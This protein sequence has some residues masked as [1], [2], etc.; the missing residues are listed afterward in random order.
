MSALIC[1]SFAYDNI[2]RF[3]GRFRDHILPD[4]IANLNVAFNV[5][6][7]RR[8]FGGC[9]GN[10]AYNLR[11]LG[12]DPL[13]LGT[14]GN[15]F[16]PYA[17][18]MERHQIPATHARVIESAYT[19]QAYITTD[20][21]DNQI[22][23]FHPGAMYHSHE[24]KVSDASGVTV[25]TVSPDGKQ[26]MVEH[27]AQFAEAGIRFFF[28]P[29]QAIPLFDGK[30]L[31]S[32]VEQ[33]TWMTVNEYEAHM[34][35][36]KTGCSLSDLM[37]HLE[38]IVVTRGK[39]GSTIHTR[40]KA[41]EIPIAKPERVVDPTGCGDAYRGGLLYGID[42]GMDWEAAGHI[43]ALA[44]AYNVEQS[45]TQNHRYDRGQF[46]QRFRDTFGFSPK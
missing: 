23:A 17:Q 33:A 39:Q 42:K 13:P 20:Q 30:E 45:G 34:V 40:D 31:L 41:I 44:G 46:D 12:G 28:D 5:D 18:W 26:G 11:L 19:A 4:Q 21:D 8:D 32:F 29:G 37:Q 7:L 14:V 15:D 10:I 27:A 24:V 35:Q 3:G 16:A 2:M 36:E 1:G 38:A 6:E 43:A 25:G 22:T 9:A